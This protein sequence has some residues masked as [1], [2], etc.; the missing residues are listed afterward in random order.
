[1]KNTTEQSQSSEVIH[2]GQMLWQAVKAATGTEAEKLI[3]HEHWTLI[4]HAL[5]TGREMHP[6]NQKFHKWMEACGFDDIKRG[7]REAALWRAREDHREW[8]TLAWP[9]LAADIRQRIHRAFSQ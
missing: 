3:S 2:L 5:L 7:D 1:M 9:L 8:L 4:G 6:S